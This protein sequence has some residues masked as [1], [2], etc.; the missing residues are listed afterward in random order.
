[1][2]LPPEHVRGIAEAGEARIDVDELTVTYEGGVVPFDLE[3]EIKVR[4]LNG[5]D[6]ID[7]TLGNEDAIS[8]YERERET[9]AT[10]TTALG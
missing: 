7:I 6:E 3:D 2:A 10:A 8:A 4:L 1:M 9:P 5:H